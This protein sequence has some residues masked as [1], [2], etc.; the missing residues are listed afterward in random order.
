MLRLISC[1]L[2]VLGDVSQR[3]FRRRGSG[4]SF[5]LLLALSL[6]HTPVQAGLSLTDAQSAWLSEHP[7]IRIGVDPDYKPFESVDE[8]GVYK[9]IAAD[10]LAL[11][12]Q[13]LGIEFQL[14]PGLTWTQVLDKV[15]SGGVDLVPVIT[16]TPQRRDFLAFTRN[17]LSFPSVIV[18]RRDHPLISGLADLANSTMALPASYIDVEQI[19]SNYPS[20]GILEVGNAQEAL[21][22]VATGQAAATQ[23]NIA[24][25]GYYIQKNN[26]FNLKISG[27]SGFPG[28]LHAIGVRRD[29]PQLVQILDQALDS[30]TQAEHQAIRNKWIPISPPLPAESAF[31]LLPEEQQWLELHPRIRVGIMNSWEPISFLNDDGRPAGISADFIAAL[32]KRLGGQL[33]LVPGQWSELLQAVQDKRLDAVLDLTPKPERRKLYHFTEPYLSIPHVIIGQKGRNDLS[34]LESLGG[35]TLALEQGFGSVA[36]FQ[37]TQPE[38]RILEY[39]NTSAALDAVARGAADVYVGNRAVAFRIMTQELM[40][41]LTAYGRARERNSV[42]AIGV[43]YDWPELAAL[44]DR[45][46]VSVSFDERNRI[47]R[48]WVNLGWERAVPVPLPPE[49][50]FPLDRLLLAA[51]IMLALVVAGAWLLRRSQI[52][53]QGFYRSRR[54]RYL[55]LLLVALLLSAVSAMA[56]LALEQGQGRERYRWGET[57]QS[58]LETTNASIRLWVQSNRGLA[59]TLASSL[60]VRQQLPALLQARPDDALPGDGA[61]ALDTFFR[62]VDDKGIG[63]ERYFQLLTPQGQVLY[64]SAGARLAAMLSDDQRASILAGNTLFLPPSR[65]DNRSGAEP[66]RL[67][68]ATAVHGDNGQALVILLMSLNPNQAFNRLLSL[69]RTGQT[70]EVYAFN[71]DAA[72]L[73]NSRFREDLIARGLLAKD[74]DSTLGLR[75]ADPGAQTATSAS[76]DEWP[77]IPMVREALADRP[78]V[79]TDGLGD[80][81]G[82]SVLSAWTWDDELGMGLVAAIDEREALEQYAYHRTTLAAVLGST[83]LLSLS[84]TVFGAWVGERANRALLRVHDELEDKVRDRTRALNQSTDQ[85]KIREERLELALK[86]G[87]LG[88]WDAD[89]ESDSLVINNRFARIYGL[90]ETQILLSREELFGRI[91]SDDRDAILDAGRRYLRG[92]VSEYG[93]EHRIESLETGLRWVVFKGAAVEW[94]PDGRVKRLVGTLQD[95][96]ERRR[97]EEA[98]HDSE[99]RLRSIFA[100]A[101]VGIALLED[102]RIIEINAMLSD[103]LGYHENEMLRQDSRLFYA[104]D[105]AWTVAGNAI[106]EALEQGDVA[107]VETQLRHKSG[108][109]VS[110][111]LSVSMLSTPRHPALTIVMVSDMTEYR[112]A[113][114]ALRESEIQLRTVFENSPVGIVHLDARGVVISCNA[115]GTEILGADR[116]TIVGL[117]CPNQLVDPDL[118][119]ALKGA[120]AGETRS[121]EGD[122]VSVSGGRRAQLRVIFNPVNPGCSPTEVIGM[123][124][125]I[126]ER[127]RL[128]RDILEA[129]EKAEEATRAKSDFLANMSHEIRTPMNAIIGMSHLA[130]QTQLDHRQRNYIDK[131]HRSAESLLG[132]IN[133][134]LDFSKI[135]AG[136]LDL[137]S[138]DFRLEDVLDNLASLVSLKAQDKGLELLFDLPPEL[139]TALVGD[140][141]R[142]GQILVNL[143]NNAVKFTER[144]EVVVQIRTLEQDSDSVR[145][146]FSVRDTGIGMTPEQ[147]GRLFESFSQ[148]D[149]STTRKYGG[150]GLG[151][152]ITRRLTGLMGGEVWVDSEAG[153]GSNFHFTVRLGKQPGVARLRHP[154]GIE[155][156]TLRALVVDDNDSSRAILVQMLA[157]FGFCVDQVPTGEAALALLESADRESP[158]DLV[159]MDW[160]MPGMDGMDAV[161]SIQRGDRITRVPTVIMVS[162]FERDEASQRASDVKLAGFLTKP[163]TPSTLLDTIAA[164]MGRDRVVEKR[165]SGRQLEVQEARARLQGAHILLVEDNEFNQELALELLSVNGIQATLA[166]NG[167][168]ALQCLQQSAFDGVLMDCQM[169]V[170]D[171]YTATREIRR[172]PRFADLPVIAMTANA[173]SGDR[174]AALTAGMNDH[175]TKPVNVDQMFVT[176]AKWIRPAASAAGHQAPALADAGT[177]PELPGIDTTAGMLTTQHNLGLYRRL[178]LKFLAGYEAFDE[179]FQQ[180]CASPD[181]D[182]PTRWA[183]TLRGV[184]GSI[185]AREVQQAAALLE[186]ACA[187]GQDPA[188][189]LLALRQVLLPVLDGLSGLTQPQHQAAPAMAMPAAG[190]AEIEPLLGQLRRLLEE[191]DTDAVNLVEQL[192]DQVAGLALQQSLRAVA[193]PLEA[194]DFEAALDALAAMEQQV[195]ELE[196]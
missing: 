31:S 152:A 70:G 179:H 140:P 135:E 47:H 182:A 63:I 180:Q 187:S 176:M 112:R 150:T 160:R 121:Y 76:P 91:L 120:L 117:D 132:I 15:Q 38:T 168:Q 98:V 49:P 111:H 183:H 105:E 171:G 149:S 10:Y 22:A 191:D 192:G 107:H 30:I 59:E 37:Q 148:V 154:V 173:M 138:I 42:L 93:C 6:F 103:I 21:S 45:A 72:M 48:K 73:S 139:P 67:H 1:F 26:L 57:L 136:K 142:L 83:L 145:L 81:R 184:A 169:P 75:L 4:V 85:L 129:K 174:E 95:I 131:V 127:K 137:E 28:G 113:E 61:G 118:A 125:D 62:R 29:W 151:L 16:D 64:R 158:F 172:Q 190:R 84:L 86:G 185:G 80:Y 146:Q 123:L 51:G 36:Y 109:L 126:S 60:E 35:K 159:L 102:R 82:V 17:Y 23:G 119:T 175:I 13:R 189:A 44:L 122:Y 134:I 124:E 165:S 188:P 50:V 25:L 58:M 144:G 39:E 128:E 77:L 101:P 147:C 156:G 92:A 194:Y 88:F 52:D 65:P 12:A 143:G 181:P 166:E 89:L 54:V 40:D 193:K 33:E 130:L 71:S 116:D 167:E 18:T 55:G 20:I 32:N 27:P 5:L 94:L 46:L 186:S 90:P 96:T 114:Q 163:V 178:L 164:A 14:V 19:A 87:D 43:R 110:A 78:A 68:F 155:A 79:S 161:R 177:L 8:N 69:G 11:I 9:G 41:G 195:A 24:V 97:I 115:K 133:D 2:V 34:D 99:E 53:F 157:T 104:D 56:W 3:S 162:A 7:V 141:L 108:G 106:Y 196:G 153:R 66:L 74:A 170:M 100:L